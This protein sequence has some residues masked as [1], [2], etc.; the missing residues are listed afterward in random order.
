MQGSLTS[1]E[2][3]SA[4]TVLTPVQQRAVTNGGIVSGMQGMFS[5]YQ[6]SPN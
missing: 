1:C 6:E 5:V 4:L 3:N 2:A